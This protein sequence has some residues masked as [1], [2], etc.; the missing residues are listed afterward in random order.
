[1]E[2][3]SPSGLDYITVAKRNNDNRAVWDRHPDHPANYDQAPGEVFMADMRPYRVARTPGI[4]QKISEQ[5]I[6]EVGAAD[7]QRR[8]TAHEGVV[9]ERDALRERLLASRAE[10]AEGTPVVPLTAT[11]PALQSPPVDQEAL[12]EEAAA[13]QA[14]AD[15][16]AAAENSG[17]TT[18]STTVPRP[19]RARGAQTTTTTETP[20]E[21]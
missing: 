19:A 9:Q 3:T 12:D 16:V 15:R 5:E 7:A 11:D 1:M 6:R 14:E 8:R 17:S 10:Q 2:E 21:R 18:T 20:P 4:S 13:E